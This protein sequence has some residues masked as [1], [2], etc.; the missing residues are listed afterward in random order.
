MNPLI[1]ALF[2]GL[3][4]G[5]TMAI[6]PGPIFFLIIQRTLN[7]GVLTGLLC[8]LGAMTADVFYA[9]IAA[10]GLTVVAHYLLAYQPIIVLLGGLFLLYLGIT[11]YTNHVKPFTEKVIAKGNG[12]NAWFSTFLLTLTNPVT[13]ISYT[14]MFAGLDVASQSLTSSLTLIFGVIVGALLVVL[15]LIGLLTYFHQKISL[16]TLSLINKTAGVLLTGFGIAAVGRG[17]VSLLS[18]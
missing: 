5:I 10:V 14:M 18:R 8:G 11:T 2:K 17:L 9:L 13:I 3:V 1:I 6:I 7:D 15:V 4:F 12:F 16:R